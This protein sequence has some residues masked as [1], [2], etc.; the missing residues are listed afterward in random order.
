MSTTNIERSVKKSESIRTLWDQRLSTQTRVAAV[1][2]T[3]ALVISYLPNLR[4]LSTLWQ[5]D[6]SYNH[7][8]LVIPIA[9]FILWQQLMNPGPRTGSEV[10]LAPWCGWVL[11]IAA[12]Y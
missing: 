5:D 8:F 1:I 9:L 7:G 2:A 11:L 4:S 6:P 12:L 10:V 3:V